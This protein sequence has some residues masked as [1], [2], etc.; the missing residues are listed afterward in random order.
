MM[1]LFIRVKNGQAFEHPIFGDNFRQAFPNVNTANLPPEFARFE[2]V[3]AP[4]IGVYEK[5]SVTYADRGDGVY[6]D[7]WT[8]LD[9]TPEEKASKQ[10]AVKDDWAIGGY[11][12]WSFDE[13][14]CSFTPPV[15]MP[16]D[17]KFYRWDEPTISWV[18][19]T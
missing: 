17:G 19:V 1:E 7:A 10:Q 5:L 2:R 11:P 12:S 4:A 15:E 18:E 9:L 14:T 6:H 3:A 8:V 16:S 13:A